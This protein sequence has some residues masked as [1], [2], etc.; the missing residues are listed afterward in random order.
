MPN[1]SAQALRTAVF[2][3]VA[4]DAAFR[5]ELAQD[6]N[7]AITARFGE[8][9]LK[10]RIENEAEK[11]LT[12]LIPSRTD[13]LARGIDAAV[14]GIGERGPSRSEF[15]AIVVQ[16][17]WSDAAFLSQLRQDPATAINGALAKFGSSVPSGV[18]VRIYEEQPGECVI[19]VPRPVD[20]SELSEAELEAV[21]GGELVVV[22]VAV[23]T[24]VVET[25][26]STVVGTV[27]GSVV[28]KTVGSVEEQRL[29][30]N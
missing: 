1:M 8:Q 25:V 13:A 28:G 12:F 15:E 29:G 27:V 16:R 2:Q 23:A 30:S 24:V 14:T 18:A 26:V 19:V 9:S 5:N 6:A 3:A 21:A 20:S 22:G 10:V 11:H 4:T 7:K 17:A